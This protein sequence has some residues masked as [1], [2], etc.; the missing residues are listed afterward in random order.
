MEGGDR[1]GGGIEARRK[2]VR[3]RTGKCIGESGGLCFQCDDV[4][5]VQVVEAL[6]G[7]LS[8]KVCASSQFSLVLSAAGKVH[9]MYI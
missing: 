7:V 2:R 5:C 4:M 9:T 8:Q 1:G 3:D 6:R